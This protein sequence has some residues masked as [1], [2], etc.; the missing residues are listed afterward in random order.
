CV[1]GSKVADKI[2]KAAEDPLFNQIRVGKEMF[3]IIGV[4]KPWPQ[5]MFISADMNNSIVIPL[6]AASFLDK[7]THID[8][9]LIRLVKRP[10]IT[11]AKKQITAVMQQLL[12]KK[13]VVFNSPEQ[14]IQLI[15]KQRQTS[16]WLLIAIGSISLIVG[17][18]G[19]MNIML[20]SV[21]ER[22]REIG[23]RMAIGAREADILRMFLIESIM[24]T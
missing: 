4:L 22:R 21:V 5:N 13:K 10:N 7:N 23:I 2:K 18:I 24:L 17:G 11:L 8:N 15:A 6:Q 12:P 1:I 19:V 20:V 9:I 16:T 14:L 3:T